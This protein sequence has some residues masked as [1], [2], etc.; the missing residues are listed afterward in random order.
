MNQLA[1]IIAIATTVILVAAYF[2]IK[3]IVDQ[4]VDIEVERKV[5][6]ILSRNPPIYSARGKDMPDEKNKLYLSPDLNGIEELD[7]QTLMLIVVEP[8]RATWGQTG[9]NLNPKIKINE[10]GIREIEVE[11]YV[12]NGELSWSLVWIRKN[13]K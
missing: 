10:Y 3:T 4:K 9:N 7:P 1:I 12:N 13:Y 2:M 11:N 6:D 8:E 5:A